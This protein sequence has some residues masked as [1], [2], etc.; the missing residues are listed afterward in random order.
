MAFQC[1]MPVP[2]RKPCLTG[3]DCVEVPAHAAERFP[4]SRRYVRAIPFTGRRVCKRHAKRGRVRPDLGDNGELE[5]LEMYL[6]EK[7]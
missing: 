2:G 1:V 7:T 6:A 5:C 4:C 3:P